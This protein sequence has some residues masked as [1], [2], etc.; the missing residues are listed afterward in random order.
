[1]IVHFK[2]NGHLDLIEEY[3]VELFIER[4]FRFLLNDRV[5][6]CRMVV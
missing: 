3:I 1:M 5:D 6:I 4:S 2:L